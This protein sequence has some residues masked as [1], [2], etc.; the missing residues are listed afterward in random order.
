V[1]Q[2]TEIKRL[3]VKCNKQL[4]EIVML[5]KTV[6]DQKG[7]LEKL[8][9]SNSAK[10]G[11]VSGKVTDEKTDNFT[12]KNPVEEYAK[13]LIR[14]IDRLQDGKLFVN[15]K[16]ACK[17]SREFYRL[18]SD[19]F[20]GIAEEFIKNNDMSRFYKFCI[21]IGVVKSHGGNC[22][23]NDVVQGK[24]TKVIFIRKAAI[25]VMQNDT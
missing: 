16:N 23:F 1:D 13:I 3:K 7:E 10:K 19:D 11:K 18:T 9:K 24:A 8:Q 14:I 17:N 21:R 2:E 4:D 15:Y 22:I 6:E 12:D 5:K 25:E 20:Q